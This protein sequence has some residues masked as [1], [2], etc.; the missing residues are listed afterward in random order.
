MVYVHVNMAKF[1]YLIPFG[2]V[3]I[4][5]S[6]GIPAQ[7][8]YAKLTRWS[9]PYDVALVSKQ[10]DDWYSHDNCSGLLCFPGKL[11]RNLH[12]ACHPAYGAVVISPETSFSLTYRGNLFGHSINI[13]WPI[14]SKFCTEHNS[15][16][17]VLCAKFENDLAMKRRV[18]RN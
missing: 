9:I 1:L 2:L 5:I 13:S 6:I 16:T 7:P 11:S 12:I 8:W 4:A 10:I 15:C 14:V 18:M 3:E 17:A